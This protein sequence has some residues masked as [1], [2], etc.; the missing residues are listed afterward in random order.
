VRIKIF[1]YKFTGKSEEELLM[2]EMLPQLKLNVFCVGLQELMANQHNY[3]NYAKFYHDLKWRDWSSRNTWF[4]KYL[5]AKNRG[6][7]FHKIVDNIRNNFSF[8]EIQKHLLKNRIF[9]NFP[10]I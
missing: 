2:N 6:E 9:F 7:N 4:F 5:F 1:S 8:S 10:K 3:K